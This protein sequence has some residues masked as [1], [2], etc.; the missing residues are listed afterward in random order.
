MVHAE[1]LT[2]TLER[3]YLP[4]YNVA[5]FDDISAAAAY[6]EWAAQ[7]PELMMTRAAATTTAPSTRPG[8]GGGDS[9]SSSSSNSDA[10]GDNKAPPLPGP[11]DP[12]YGQPKRWLQ[13]QVLLRARGSRARCDDDDDG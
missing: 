1:D 7:M 3:G 8:G 6:P 2:S 4:S 12:D 11:D 13:Y 10:N 9:S 5:L